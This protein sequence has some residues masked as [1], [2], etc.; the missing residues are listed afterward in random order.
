METEVVANTTKTTK[1][2][3]TNTTAK[4][5]NVYTIPRI[6]YRVVPE[7]EVERYILKGY[8]LVGGAVVKY[9]CWYQ[10]VMLQTTKT[11][12]EEEY[13]RFRREYGSPEG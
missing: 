4:T 10:A 1:K 3:S 7:S 9:S 8:T 5:E 6:D 12:T 13:D 11:V 2:K